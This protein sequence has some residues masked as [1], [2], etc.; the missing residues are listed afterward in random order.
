MVAK[1][2]ATRSESSKR[3]RA[4]GLT[5]TRGV[6]RVGAL[7]LVVF[8]VIV[9]CGTRTDIDI[10]SAVNDITAAVFGMAFQWVVVP[11]HDLDR[12]LHQTRARITRDYGA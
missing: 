1:E 2:K 5:Y 8:G 10:D 6:R 9:A 7:A 12:E 11:G 4:L 3:R